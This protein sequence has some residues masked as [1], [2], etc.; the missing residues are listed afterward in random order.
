MTGFEN[1]SDVQVDDYKLEKVENEKYLGDVI[2]AD[3]TNTKNVISRQN[4]SYGINKQIGSMLREVCYG[5]YFFEV[6]MIYRESLLLSSI[7]TN[8]EAWYKVTKQD[9]DTLEKC[10]ESLLRMVFE[11]PCTTTKCMLY[12]E[13]GVRPIRFHI[14]ARRLMFL[15]YI[16]N[17]DESSLIL[18]F[19]KAQMTNPGKGDWINQVNEDLE[20]LE[21][22]LT[23]KQLKASSLE[24]FRTLV[25]DSIDEKV[26]EY[27]IEDKNKKD[28]SKVSHLRYKNHSMQSY[29]K[30]RNISIQL[31][32]FMFLLRSRMLDVSAN[33]PSKSASKFCPLCRDEESLDTQEHLFSCINVISEHKLIRN[34]PMYS[35][36]FGE[37]VDKMV[38][39]ATI[40]KENFRR[41][42]DILKKKSISS[43]EEEPCEPEASLSVLQ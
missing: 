19:F 15:W 29:L 7:L 35:D 13:S 18:R 24:Q 16:L 3:G 9:I 39:V 31:K 5:P 22:Y 12:L 21:I 27:L 33:Y 10:D 30:S 37:D 23:L 2:S 14:M 1:L 17:E 28:K 25:E 34:I 8:S 32:K 36:I 4:K 42:K 40:M 43:P 20:Y 41:R 6:A 38:E 26:F 11:T